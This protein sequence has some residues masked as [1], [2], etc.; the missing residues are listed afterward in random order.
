M[1]ERRKKRAPIGTEAEAD[2]WAAIIRN[3]R[4][5]LN[6]TQEDLAAKVGTNQATI[7]RWERG[8]SVPQVGARRMLEDLCRRNGL[9][10]VNDFATM[11]NASPFPMILVNRR[12]HVVAASASSGF[13]AGSSTV[14]QTPVEE[15]ALLAEFERALEDAGFWDKARARHDYDVRVGGENRRAVVTAV[16]M[17][18][19]VHALVQKAWDGARAT[20]RR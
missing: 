4:V 20:P 10:L 17:R 7:S 13:V 12:G 16:S 14:E 1:R 11:V 5:A 18:G 8:K 19:E 9:A 3:L 6:A 15:R 2:Y